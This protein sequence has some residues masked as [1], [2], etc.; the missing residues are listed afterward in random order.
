MILKYSRNSESPKRYILFER[1]EEGHN[2]NRI[3][4]VGTHTGND[5]L[6]SRLKEHF[7]IE[8]KDRS[9]FRKH[10]GRSILNKNKDPFLDQWNWDLTERVNRDRY[11]PL[12]D[13]EKQSEVESQVTNY[14]QKNLSFVVLEI[15]EKDYRID[16]EKKIISTISLCNDC[17]SSN[18]WIGNS[19]PNEKIKQSGLWLVQGLYKKPLSEDEFK[20]ISTT[21]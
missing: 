15:K 6:Y 16:I 14:I 17:F 21:F 12:L 19:S 1:G 13:K 11:S 18:G 4:R 10:I 5:L 9:I 8:N 20:M 3:V 7:Y 2:S